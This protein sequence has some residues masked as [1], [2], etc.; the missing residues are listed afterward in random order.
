MT[1]ALGLLIF[2]ANGQQ[3]PLLK[4]SENRHHLVTEDNQPFF[5]LGDTAW[6][7]IHRLTRGEIDTYLTDRAA[8]GFNVIQTVVL[9]ELDGLNTPNAY[10]DKPLHNNNPEM[11][12]EPY[13]EVVDYVIERAAQLGLYV[14]L[15]PTWGDKFNMKWGVG[16]EIFTPINA[17]KYG[18]L[19]AKRYLKNNNIIW[20]LGG[21]RVPEN[22]DHFAIIRAMAAGIREVDNRHLMTYHPMGAHKASE[23]FGDDAWFDVDMFQSGHSRLAKEYNFVL[24]GRRSKVVRPVINGES[25]YENIMDRFWEEEHHGW[26]DDADARVSAYW[27][28]LA[29]AAGYTYGCNDVWQM[30]DYTREP[31]LNART[32]WRMALELPGASQL[33]FMKGLFTAIPWTSLELNQSLILNDNPEDESYILSAATQDK[34]LIIAYTPAGKPIT[35]DLTAMSVQKAN[36]WWF[37]PRS[38]ELLTIGNFETKTQME[39]DPWAKGRGSDFLLIIAGEEMNIGLSAISY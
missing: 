13:F 19:L 33:K 32:G 29:G 35:V 18:E 23:F 25:R 34:A 38:G 2:A 22:A 6:E 12:N 24:E 20:V 3:M 1:I 11:L 26:L 14:G 9:A 15:L 30:Y 10:G 28:M 8:R 21:D 7:L 27:T 39:F 5:W 31:N 36:A 37:N 16:P 17:A 4:V